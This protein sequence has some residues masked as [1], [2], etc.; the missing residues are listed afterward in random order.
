MRLYDLPQN[1][2]GGIE[3]HYAGLVLRFHHLDGMYSYCVV[4]E[5]KSK[6][7]VFNL[8]AGA[9]IVYKEDKIVAGKGKDRIVKIHTYYEVEEL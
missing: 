4:D 9:P 2:V 8:T 6:G 5:G 1:V 3:L 7:K